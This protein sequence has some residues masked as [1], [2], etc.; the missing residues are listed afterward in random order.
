MSTE[1]HIPEYGNVYM[2]KAVIGFPHVGKTVASDFHLISH[3]R[4]GAL[5]LDGEWRNAQQIALFL[6]ARITGTIRHINI[7]GCAFGKGMEGR[8]AVA[9]IAKAT[10][11]TISASDD[12]TGRD[13][14]WVLEVGT[15][16]TVTSSKAYNGN[17]QYAATDDFD[18]DGIQN[19]YDIDDDNDGVPD[20]VESPAC[21]YTAT[22][23]ESGNRSGFVT[24]TTGLNMNATYNAPQELTDGDAGT[25][26][27]N[28][29]VNFINAQSNAGANIYTFEF[30]WPVKLS[31]IYLGYVSANSHFMN[32]AVV[33]LEGSN[34]GTNWTDLNT[35]ATYNQAN[36]NGYVLD[37]G[38]KNYHL[39]PVTQNAA[40]YKYYRI[41]GVSGTIGNNGT[42]NEVYFE[43]SPGIYSLNNPA[44]TNDTDSDGIL[45]HFDTDSDGDG[46]FD[47]Y[48]AAVTGSTL[49]GT[50]T[51]SITVAPNTAGDVGANGLSNSVERAVDNAVL[52]YSSTYSRYATLNSIRACRDTDGDSIYDLADIDDDNDGVTD[53]VECPSGVKRMTGGIINLTQGLPN[54]TQPSDKLH[55]QY[56]LVITETQKTAPYARLS[57]SFNVF[58]H[59]GDT[60]NKV[61]FLQGALGYSFEFFDPFTGVKREQ[62][63]IRITA[64]PASDGSLITLICYDLNGNIIYTNTTLPDISTYRV[65]TDSTINNSRIH[66]FII[67]GSN[68]TTGFDQ[69]YVQP[70]NYFTGT[71]DIDS[72]GFPNHTDLD[73][74]ADKCPDA[75]E[76]GVYSN[77]GASGSMSASGGGIY[78]GGIDTGIA[79]AYVGSGTPGQY[80]ANGFFNAIETGTESGIYNG[81]YTYDHAMLPGYSRCADSDGDGIADL[82]DIDD[83]NDGI[84]DVNE[85]C[86]VKV[87]GKTGIIVTKPAT[88]D[89]TFDGSQTLANMVDGTD[90]ND[91]IINTPTG[92]LTNSEWFRIEFPQA[93]VLTYWEIGHYTNQR[94]FSAATVYKVQGSINGY[95]WTDL[96]GSLSYNNNQTGLSTQNS[97]NIA[98]FPGN[99]I[100]YKYYRYYG[101]GTAAAG[102]G[103]ATEFYFKGRCSE[104]DTDNDGIANR[105]D[106]DS[107]GDGC[108]D[109][110]EAGVTGRTLNGSYTDSLTIVH[111]TTGDAGSN[112]LANSVETS[113][114][115]GIVNYIS[116]YNPYAIFASYASCKDTDGDGIF[117]IA[118]I[119]DDNDGVL[120][121]EEQ[122]CISAD[123]NTNASSEINNIFSKNGMAAG[124]TLFDQLA[125]E[126]GLIFSTDS[127][128]SSGISLANACAEPALYGG[129]WSGNIWI[130]SVDPLDTSRPVPL[131]SITFKE[132]CS[133]SN[134]Y[135]TY[136]AYD[137][138]G[139][140]LYT[141]NIVDNMPQVAGEVFDLKMAPGY[142][143]YKIKVTRSNNNAVVTGV[144]LKEGFGVTVCDI[145]M[146]NDNDGIPNRLDLDSD[147]DGCT[148][149]K[150]AI[151][152]INS[153]IPTQSGLIQNGSGGSVTS[154]I[155]LEDARVPGPYGGNG[156]A[157]TLQATADSNN[158]KYI[159]TYLYLATEV[160]NNA[161][162]DLDSDAVADFSEDL[163]LDDDGIPNAL[164]APLCFFTEAQAID[165][166]E[167]VTSDFAWSTSNP[168]SRT[169]DNDA[170]TFGAVVSTANILN[171]SLITFDLPV[172]ATDVLDT[173]RLDVGS[174]AFGN[175]TWHLEGRTTAS[176]WDTL[177]ANQSMS[178]ANT[179]YNFINTLRP[180]EEYHMYRIVGSS[181]TVI[182]NNARLSEFYIYYKNFNA[183]KH[184]AKTGCLLDTDND[185]SPNFYDRDSDG[186]GCSDAVESGVSGT[187]LPGDV[188]VGTGSL[189]D[190]AAAA[191]PY[192]HNGLADGVETAPESGIINYISTYNLYAVSEMLNVCLDSDV[193]SVKD[194][195]DIDDDNDGIIDIEEE[196][197]EIR[198]TPKSGITI[199]KPATINYVFDG[200]QTLANLIDG[201]DANDYIMETPSGTLNNSEW[202][203]V[204]FAM[205]KLLLQWEIGQ[206]TNQ[207]LF[208]TTSTY[209]VQGSHDGTNWTD[210]TGT[211]TYTNNQT[212]QSSQSNSNI[213]AFPQNAIAYKYYRYFGISATSGVGWATEF[214]FR[215]RNCA[216]RDTDSDNI[217]DRLDLDSDGDG[218]P[219]AKE[220]GISDNAG[221]A[222]SM[223]ASGGSIYSG[224]IEPGTANAYVGN[225]MPSQYSAN[226]YFNGIETGTES[227]LYNGISTY[228]RY[229]LARNWSLCADTDNDNIL[230]VADIDDDNDGILDAMESPACFFTATEV[231]TLATVSSDFTYSASPNGLSAI[232]DHNAATYGQIASANM[233]G[234]A[235]YTLTLPT[236]APQKI[237]SVTDS[238]GTIAF[239]TG[240]WILEGSNNGTTWDTL[241]AAQA[242]N[243]AN[244]KYTFGNTLKPNNAY[245][246][247]RLVGATNNSTAA[248][249]RLQE[250]NINYVV[251]TP[252]ANPKPACDTDTDFDGILNHIDLDSDGDK[253]PD[254][255]EAGTYNKSGVTA[256]NGNMQNGGGGVVTSAMPTA[257]AV[258][259]GPYSGNGFAD[260][261]QATTDTNSYKYTY[262]YNV[263]TDSTQKACCIASNT[264]PALSKTADTV[265]SGTA[266]NLNTLVTSNAPAYNALRWFTDNTHTNTYNT[267]AAATAGTYYAFYKD[268]INN[269][270]SPASMAFTLTTKALPVGSASPQTICS[271][272]TTAVVLNATISGATYTWTAALQSGSVSGFSN[273]ISGCGSTIAQTLTGAGVVRYTVTPSANGCAGN[274][275]TVDVTVSAVPTATIAYSGSPYTSGSGTANVTHTGQTGGTYSATPSGL[276]INAATGQVNINSSFANTYT[277]KYSFSNGTCTDS[278]TA[279]L[280]INATNDTVTTTPSCPT[281][282]VTVCA[283]ADDV[284]TTGGA[285]YSTPCGT[286]AGYTAGTVG[287]G[288]CIT[289]TP[290][291]TMTDTVEACIVTCKN[292][293]C[294]T[295]RILLYP[296]VQTVNHD[297]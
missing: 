172:I 12:I 143:V 108:Y 249:A 162:T 254:A 74:D 288:G 223:S 189:L 133:G 115:N 36:T 213:A 283:V 103:W 231:K 112:G 109:K 47:K 114:D 258:I 192:G 65:T 279:T 229:A 128:F 81:A 82:D 156:F 21:F 244:T 67:F 211:L 116:N 25:A 96:T 262:T 230:D 212:G 77:A 55:N 197:C 147:G 34:N 285:A 272:K 132:D 37:Q 119:D 31:N 19:Q 205:P 105:L 131:F 252:S 23:F 38:L 8:K 39:F 27:A 80:N 198:N 264:A 233:L 293:K 256:V 30:S 214:Y 165:I 217:P 56:G 79:N 130:R 275:F 273:C 53:S 195:A 22:E 7:Y 90:A 32:G 40:L 138:N 225:G 10:G 94:L 160:S 238:V 164:E 157:D 43:Q 166:T 136:S 201:T 241:S 41:T 149:T 207:T 173:V 234:K 158:Y 46:C 287:S 58:P 200:A 261:L 218:C 183:S 42:S 260:V 75:E 14:D 271:G 259:G 104:P 51:D 148:D 118:D 294:D 220:A 142:N 268:T 50:Y 282:P 297:V 228:T 76:S 44:C 2:D 88:I 291:G 242:M 100:P 153:D 226:G 281:C 216:D 129:N 290:D 35:G 184:P 124:I 9:Y 257:N 29:A 190:K 255:Y 152:Y 167:E 110:F 222:A 123:Y 98:T 121:K 224:G 266:Y 20:A 106:L 102:S 70:L 219:D 59:N 182:T 15:P 127:T 4:P 193:D 215:E 206:Y 52:N 178:S 170:A 276:S 163:D 89:Y 134:E 92:I 265:C 63:S 125:D 188:H 18:N 270:F 186:D 24:A 247:Y 73:S 13:G 28:Y 151:L 284:D 126:T 107:D 295:T 196:N 57:A 278:I 210:L 187:L 45:N 85:G 194:V 236:F 199:T 176:T 208:S 204:E 68:N 69:L 203:R 168:L 71:C 159:Y 269:C 17:L 87:L 54:G 144:R 135:L 202:F 289:Y 253:C 66:R 292:G 60:D 235:L 5:L 113:A 237:V 49:N 180:D 120:D 248:N 209:K 243:T 64:D 61:I 97:S 26:A 91:Y 48:E 174:T 33:K 245:G 239:G 93:T 246:R 263:A 286:P 171:K 175:G 72:D 232:N 185:G 250:I 280:T 95:T 227:G 161:C 122:Q 221:A 274:A 11:L 146:D 62:D 240:T 111:N 177:S 141:Y 83:D 1:N 3:G 101:L 155:T 117:D 150:E 181:S 296:P 84:T 154:T 169:Y 86:K 16:V 179:T 145:D 139:I 6:K 78:S 267:P 137:R 140:F 277:V 191:G 99:S 251:Y